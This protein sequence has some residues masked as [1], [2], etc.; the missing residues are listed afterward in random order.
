M[1]ERRRISMLL[2]VAVAGAVCM[3]TEESR[4]EV[5]KVSCEKKVRRK[6]KM[7]PT[8]GVV[9]HLEHNQGQRCKR[10]PPGEVW[11]SCRAFSALFWASLHWYGAQKLVCSA[12]CCI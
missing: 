2:R 6:E 4:Q 3:E 7:K 12:S 10:R 9:T 5:V 8:Q 1:K 11:L